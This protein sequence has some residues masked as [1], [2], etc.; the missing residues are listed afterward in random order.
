MK[1]T[2]QDSDKCMIF[3][4]L[5]AH[6]KNLN[7][8]VTIHF[9]DDFFFIKDIDINHVAL[10]EIKLSKEWF[11]EYIVEPDDQ[12]TI[13]IVS[14]FIHKVMNIRDSEQN[15]IWECN[16]SSDKLDINFTS[17]SSNSSKNK[18][19]FDKFFELPI[20]DINK[21]TLDIPEI[22]YDV[23]MMIPTSIFATIMSQLEV[24]DESVEFQCSEDKIVLTALSMEGN[25][26]VTQIPVDSL[27]EYSIISELEE[28]IKLKYSLLYIH[29]FT[30]FHKISDVLEIN[31]GREYPIQFKYT[32]NDT[33]FARFFLAP[34]I[35]DE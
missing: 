33:S 15:I 25:K 31:I 11:D 21:D 22:D 9:M 3:S 17:N 10:Y 26:M 1:L 34:K 30:N 29:K 14:E 28:P 6:I 4:E 7:P 35:D 13:S 27:N 24:F 18:M 16:E 23:D 20:M 12:K 5:F 32:I 19:S 2:I 8:T